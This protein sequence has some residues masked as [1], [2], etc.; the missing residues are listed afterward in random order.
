MTDLVIDCRESAL[1]LK[2]DEM[3]A[4]YTSEQLTIGDVQVRTRQTG[5]LLFVA[6][7]KT[8]AD[9]YSS[10]VDGRFAEQRERLKALR[11]PNLKVCYILENYNS[12]WRNAQQSNVVSGALENLVL[13]HGI[14][15]LPTVDLTQTAKVVVSI[16]KKVT[17][18]DCSPSTSNGLK[19]TQKKEVIMER[20]FE[21]QLNLI[22]GVSMKIAEA[23]VEK[24]PSPRALIREYEALASES[25]RHTLLSTL[26]V[27]KR[28]LGI[29]VSKRIAEVYLS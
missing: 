17:G 28:K 29:V 12:R 9:L 15:V 23:I 1:Q 13:T 24:Y 18:A 2:L 26:V 22:P 19:H 11:E 6:E 25:E 10:I 3:N 14:A 5:Q 16:A 20:L 21:H 8:G 7:R 4:A 27:G